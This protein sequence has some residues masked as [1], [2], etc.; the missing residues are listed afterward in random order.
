MSDKELTSS[1]LF[2]RKS[3]DFDR[4]KREGTRLQTP[5]FNLISTLSSSAGVRVGIVVGRR[6]GKAVT[7][8]R[9]KRIFRELV[10]KTNH[11]L[12]KGHDL[13]VFPKRAALSTNHRALTE[14]WMEALA[15]EGL[16]VSFNTP[17]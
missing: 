14:A 6:M 8:N 12:V 17:S 2:L 15:H 9:A 16:V 11:V 7:R 13:I 3:K 1:L 5:L 10:R 4:V